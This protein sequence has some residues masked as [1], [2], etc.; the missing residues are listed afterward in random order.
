MSAHA[1]LVSG[2][3]LLVAALLASALIPSGLLGRAYDP[4]FV[5]KDPNAKDFAVQ[6]LTLL[7]D[8]SV[9]RLSARRSDIC[10]LA[11]A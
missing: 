4:L 2:G 1:A 8:V 10:C 11:A 5:L 3:C 6:E 7:A 9:E